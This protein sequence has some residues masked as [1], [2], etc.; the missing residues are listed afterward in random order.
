M[1]DDHLCDL[2]FFGRPAYYEIANKMILEVT[3]SLLS[4]LNVSNGPVV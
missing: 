1:P 3:V 2:L 4:A